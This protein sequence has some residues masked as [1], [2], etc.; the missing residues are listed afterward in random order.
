MST[1]SIASLFLAQ[2]IYSEK[3]GK[4]IKHFFY[5]EHAM[6]MYSKHNL[7]VCAMQ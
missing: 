2:R 4:I 5:V 3:K 7:Y 6:G 1:E